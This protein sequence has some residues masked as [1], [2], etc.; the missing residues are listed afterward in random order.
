MV[1]VSTSNYKVQL[2]LKLVVYAVV[3]RMISFGYDYSWAH[4]DARFDYEVFNICDFYTCLFF[5]VS[6]FSLIS[7]SCV[8]T[9]MHILGLLAII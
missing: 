3:L 9:C 2:L 6:F 1:F 4:Q 7:M 5:Y 8:F